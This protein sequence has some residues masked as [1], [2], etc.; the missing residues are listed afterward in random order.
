VVEL[1]ETTAP[2]TRLPILSP[3]NPMICQAAAQFIFDAGKGDMN[4]VGAGA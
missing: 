3:P 1:V 2:T 4:G